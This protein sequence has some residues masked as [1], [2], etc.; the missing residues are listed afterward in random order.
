M[1]AIALVIFTIFACFAG[2]ALTE[3]GC[4]SRAKKMGLES[5]W[6]PVQGCMVKTQKR[7]LPIE[8]LR[9]IDP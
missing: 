7:W 3:Y 8:A 6:G 1:N 9:D 5:E 4:S 2:C